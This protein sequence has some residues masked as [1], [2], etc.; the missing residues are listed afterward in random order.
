MMFFPPGI[1]P[2]VI[3]NYCQKIKVMREKQEKE[4]Q[5]ETLRKHIE[6]TTN[7]SLNTMMAYGILYTELNK[8]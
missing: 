7:V 6:N 1:P 5:L 8:L 2:D 4:K 3:E